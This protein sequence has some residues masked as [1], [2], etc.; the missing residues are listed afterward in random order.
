MVN[1]FIFWKQ[2]IFFLCAISRLIIITDFFLCLYHAI[3]KEL[4]LSGQGFIWPAG[5][6][7]AYGLVIK[8]VCH[9]K[10]CDCKFCGDDIIRWVF[11]AIIMPCLET[12]KFNVLNFG[13]KYLYLEK[14]SNFKDLSY[15]WGFKCLHFETF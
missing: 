1:G 6:S 11:I 7:F 9:E 15:L 5:R 10:P 3:D 8:P 2:F 4:Q 14:L 13:Y 12:F